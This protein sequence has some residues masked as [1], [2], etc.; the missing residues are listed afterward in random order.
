MNKKHLLLVVCYNKGFDDSDTIQSLC[1]Y[2][3]DFRQF[4]LEIWDNSPQSMFSV[5]ELKQKLSSF[6]H[7]NY[8]HTPKNTSLSVVYNT[9]VD[10]LLFEYST[11]TIL[12]HD[13]ELPKSFFYEIEN[14]RNYFIENE[15][16]IL[17]PKVFFKD[18]LISPARQIFFTG[19]Y[20]NE[21]PS[22]V[23]IKSKGITAISSGM[24]ISTYFFTKYKFRFNE[25]L[26]LYGIDNAFMKE[27]RTLCI[28]IYLINC[29]IN[30]NLN[31][32]D[33][34]ENVE[35]KYKRFIDTMNGVKQLA[36]G[37]IFI[38]TF[39]YFYIFMKRIEFLIKNKR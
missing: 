5:G 7:L 20:I 35:L 2:N 1:K 3:I 31:Y 15:C 38:Q 33:K 24:I 6:S 37:N 36:K 21:L 32:F 12:D 16:Y 34:L 18:Q 28:S 22:S 14:S 11:F 8:T 26:K 39:S 30:H 23:Y 27:Y 4:G 13:S 25:K 29:N 9:I 10:N 17:L 19:K